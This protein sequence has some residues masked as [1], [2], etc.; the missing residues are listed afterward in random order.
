MSFPVDLILRS[1]AKTLSLLPKWPYYV[2]ML[3]PS[4]LKSGLK[5]LSSTDRGLW[6]GM[7]I[8]TKSQFEYHSKSASS[9]GVSLKRMCSFCFE[10]WNDIMRCTSVLQDKLVAIRRLQS[11]CAARQFY[12]SK[13]VQ[14]RR[15]LVNIFTRALATY[16]RTIRS[17]SAVRYKW[18][19][20]SEKL[21]VRS[22]VLRSF[23]FTIARA[24]DRSCLWS[25][26]RIVLT[27]YDM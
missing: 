19:R 26:A 13:K 23:V 5:S 9:Y 12:S 16:V 15:F 7:R 22:L 2:D 24:Y 8:E 21:Y 6:K 20:T 1:R 25:I 11:F 17:R 4:L 18:S 3:P 27:S 14:R 10:N